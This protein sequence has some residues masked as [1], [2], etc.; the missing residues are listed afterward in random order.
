VEAAAVLLAAVVVMAV[1]AARVTCK[2][3][4]WSFAKE[5]SETIQ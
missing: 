3:S 5:S 1:V 2:V 4:I